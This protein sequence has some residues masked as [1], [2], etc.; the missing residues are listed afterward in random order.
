MTCKIN[1]WHLWF[2]IKVKT[3]A[4]VKLYTPCVVFL[5]S[6][7]LDVSSNVFLETK[8]KCLESHLWLWEILFVCFHSPLVALFFFFKCVLFWSVLKFWFIIYIFSLCFSLHIVFT[9]QLY[10]CTYQNPKLA[11][12]RVDVSKVGCRTSHVNFESCLC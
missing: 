2:G 3:L 8:W 1:L 4:Y 12:V 10:A 5:C 9:F 11:H 7:G 6:V